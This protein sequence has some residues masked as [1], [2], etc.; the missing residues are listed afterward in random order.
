[1]KD[2]QQRNPEN[3]MKHDMNNT[4]KGEDAMALPS[5]VGYAQKYALKG[6]QAP[7]LPESEHQVCRSADSAC[8]TNGH[9]NPVRCAKT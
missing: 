9:T 5:A 7:A 2:A 1:M 8:R 4:K 6:A 3:A